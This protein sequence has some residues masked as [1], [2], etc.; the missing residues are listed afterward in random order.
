M[1]RQLFF[2][3]FSSGMATNDFLRRM[4]RLGAMRRIEELRAEA[5]EILSQFP[6]LGRATPTARP[7]ASAPAAS[8]GDGSRKRRRRKMTAA[9]R[10]AVGERMKKYWEKRRAGAAKTARKK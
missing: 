5:N 2:T 9:Q 7:Q 4:A 10:K 1:R 3:L 8:S 6:E